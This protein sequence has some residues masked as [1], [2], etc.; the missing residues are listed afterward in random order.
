MN[1]PGQLAAKKRDDSHPAFAQLKLV[2]PLS[3][4]LANNAFPSSLSLMLFLRLFSLPLLRTGRRWSRSAYFWLALAAGGFVSAMLSSGGVRYVFLWLASVASCYFFL[5]LIAHLCLELGL[6][7]LARSKCPLCHHVFGRE[8]AAAAFAAHTRFCS[9]FIREAK[10]AFSIDLG[11]AF[12]FVC[13]QCSKSLFFDYMDM[14]DVIAGDDEEE[15]HEDCSL[16][17]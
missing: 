6:R 17:L 2:R 1:L 11:G 10:G 13:P 5:C 14:Q 8:H 9:E 4:P 7:K 16:P 15:E 3:S 12:S